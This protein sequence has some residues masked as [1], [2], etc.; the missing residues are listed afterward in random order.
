M[1]T[2]IS[3][4][5]PVTRTRH[6]ERVFRL[7][8]AACF[9]TVAGAQQPSA[10]R[11]APPP[12]WPGEGALASQPQDRHV[13]ISP[14]G[15]AIIVRSPTDWAR[16]KG[17][18]AIIRY[19]LHNRLLPTVLAQMSARPGE[20]TYNYTIGNGRDAKDIIQIWALVVPDAGYRPGQPAPPDSD[21]LSGSDHWNGAHSHPPIMRQVELPDQPRGRIALWLQDEPGRMISPG[22]SQTGFRIE[23]SCRPGFTTALFGSGE[24]PNIDQEFPNEIFAQLDSYEDPTWIY[25]PALTFGPMFCGEM[26][27]AAIVQNMISGI[28]RSIETGRLKSTSEFARDALARLNVLSAA[29]STTAPAIASPPSGE[30]EEEIFTALQ[31]SLSFRTVPR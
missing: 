3:P 19:D 14:E 7:I 13:F 26:P 4:I 18:P 5:Q 20:Y 25:V 23:S 10:P 24:S 2:A 31:L 11:Y 15:D 8:F 16:A 17:K 29:D 22:R 30:F 9:V 28:K 27:R 1:Y 6:G 12:V 21:R